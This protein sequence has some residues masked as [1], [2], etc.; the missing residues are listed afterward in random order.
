MPFCGGHIG[1]QIHIKMQ[2]CREPPRIKNVYKPF[3]VVLVS[4]RPSAKITSHVNNNMYCNDHSYTVLIQSVL[5]FHFSG[6]K[7]TV[8]MFS[9]VLYSM[10]N[11]ALWWQPYWISGQHNKQEDHL[12][13]K[14]LSH[15]AD[16]SGLGSY[17]NLPTTG[18]FI[19]LAKINHKETNE[20]LWACWVIMK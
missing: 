5:Y 16:C 1:F 20:L 18:H 8:L 11:Y 19:L 4:I 2:T 6:I 12:A 7:K 14:N 13:S 9:H 17:T 15:K 3:P 10:L